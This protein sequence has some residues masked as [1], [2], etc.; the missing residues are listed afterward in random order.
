LSTPRWPPP[1]AIWARQRHLAGD[2]LWQ[3]SGPLFTPSFAS[4]QGPLQN[5]TI[6]RHIALGVSGAEAFRIE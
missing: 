5:H 3:R 1:S 2:D 4:G 6:L